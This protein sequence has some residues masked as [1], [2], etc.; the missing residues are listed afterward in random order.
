MGYLLV[1]FVIIDGFSINK[2]GFMK[3]HGVVEDDLEIRSVKCNPRLNEIS[4]GRHRDI[5]Y[6]RHPNQGLMTTE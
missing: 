1:F 5:L 6:N 2:V 3:Y 4:S